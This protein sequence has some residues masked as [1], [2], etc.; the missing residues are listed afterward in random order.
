MYVTGNNGLATGHRV[1]GVEGLGAV[2]TERF[3]ELFPGRLDG[4]KVGHVCHRAAGGEVGQDDRLVWARQH[5]G[6]FSHKVN[7]AEDDGFCIGAGL[8]GIGELEA[9]TEKVG[10]LHDFVALVEVAED[11]DAL[12]EG[13]L[14]RANAEVQL[15]RGCVA[16]L[17]G[18]HPLPRRVWRNGV[19]CGGAGAV[20]GWHR[21]DGP[22]VQGEAGV[23]GGG[24]GG[25]GLA[26]GV[27]D[28]DQ[29][30]GWGDGWQG[31]VSFGV[32]A[33]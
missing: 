23:A 14:G 28:G 27:E 18:K 6:G 11:D 20:G 30:R 29:R 3:G 5:V 4:L 21:V 31:P 16:I 24:E 25:L 9:V 19:E 1:G 12:A 32:T 17:G 13:V 7:A 26:G 22:G 33:L 10:M 15:F 8:G 2:K